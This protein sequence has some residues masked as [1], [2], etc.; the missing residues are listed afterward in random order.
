MAYKNTKPITEMPTQLFCTRCGSPMSATRVLTYY[1]HK[2]GEPEF[3]WHYRCQSLL[4]L[5]FHGVRKYDN[6][7]EEIIERYY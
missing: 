6:S 5:F 3:E 4:G 2:S 7:G 1:D